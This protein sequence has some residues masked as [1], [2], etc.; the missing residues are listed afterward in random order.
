MK[1]SLEIKQALIQIAE[2]NGRPPFE[3]YFVR[4]VVRAIR[5]GVYHPMGTVVEAEKIDSDFFATPSLNTKQDQ[6]AAF[7]A[8]RGMREILSKNSGVSVSYISSVLSHGTLLT[9]SAWERLSSAFDRTETEVLRN[10]RNTKPHGTTTRYNFGCRCADCKS[11]ISSVRK[12]EYQ[13]KKLKM[14]TDKYCGV[15][16]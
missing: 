5:S 14:M 4:E 16:V 10:S 9:D 7:C 6:L 15:R 2:R 1:T 11:A 3:L 12:D 13:A 8:P